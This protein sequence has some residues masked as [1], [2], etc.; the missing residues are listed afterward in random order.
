MECGERTEGANG[1]RTALC[2]RHPA[3][4]AV[5]CLAVFLAVTA[6][7]IEHEL[8]TLGMVRGVANA[9]H[10]GL[11]A[12]LTCSMVAAV[13]TGRGQG[14]ALL[15]LMLVGC[16]MGGVACMPG[17]AHGVT[18]ACAYG[19][20]CLFT[21]VAEEALLCG[22]LWPCMRTAFGD[23]RRALLS[24]A[25]IFAACHLG[26]DLPFL[27]TGARVGFAVPFGVCMV[28]LFR[29]TGYLWVPAVCHAVFD[30]VLF[31]CVG[32]LV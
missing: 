19:A 21:G 30:A 25:V 3:S 31:L 22:V 24:A 28:W 9:L 2:N 17:V 13:G 14:R 6:L 26:G 7:P 8:E 16:A 11:L 5:V 12:V 10:A 20:W 15:T 29:R 23:G 27:W 1:T 4:V 18:E 32:N